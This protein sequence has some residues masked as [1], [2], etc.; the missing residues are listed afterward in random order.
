MG[1]CEQQLV[2]L[3]AGDGP[4]KVLVGY[5]EAAMHM[6]VAGTER[7]VTVDEFGMAQLYDDP[8]GH[9]PI[10]FKVTAGEA[11]LYRNSNRPEDG[12]HGYGSVK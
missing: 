4:V 6:E 1:V 9:R 5:S 12:Y 10:S 11:G 8:E 7:Y 3:H 2:Y